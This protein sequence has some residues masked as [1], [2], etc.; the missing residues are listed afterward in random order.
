[1]LKQSVSSKSNIL[2]AAVILIL[3]VSQAAFSQSSPLSLK[4]G[5]DTSLYKSDTV[6]MSATAID[7]DSNYLNGGELAMGLTMFH[8][9]SL[10]TVYIPFEYA[11]T[12]NFYLL[13][14]IPDQ[15]K[16]SVYN[17]DHNTIMG[18]G[19]IMLGVTG[20]LGPYRYFSSST[21][22]RVTLPTGNVN[23]QMN[24]SYI[25]MGNGGYTA[26]AQESFSIGAFGTDL[27]S[28]RLFFSGLGVYYFKSSM[29][30]DAVTEYNYD[31]NYLWSAMG[32]IDISLAKRFDIECKANY[33]NLKER[34]YKIKTTTAAAGS[35]IDGND[36]IKQINVVPFLR[37]RFFD[38]MT[39]QVG[40]IYPVKTT[41]DKDIKPAYDPGWKIV[42]GIEKRFSD[43]SRAGDIVKE[44]VPLKK[45]P[46]YKRPAVKEEFK[47]KENVKEK[48]K[49]NDQNAVNSDSSDK[50]VSSITDSSEKPKKTKTKTKHRR[51]RRVKKTD[52]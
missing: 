18:F 2:T 42:M 22:A 28:F 12:D 16:T 7:D 8:S 44:K 20:A 35:W 21:T 14:S 29:D 51:K 48:A 15:T 36:S 45:S 17:N 27:I 40:V 50:R 52:D 6:I 39:G 13:F 23:A 49:E 38:D 9:P 30:I 24:G 46:E 37:Y 10:S 32:G 41:Q 31:K 33:I 43:D 19:D 1:M 5:V 34:R 26:S 4:G 47:E 25:P 3:F 11:L